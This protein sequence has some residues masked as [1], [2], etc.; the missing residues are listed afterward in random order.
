M[1]VLLQLS[2]LL[3]PPEIKKWKKKILAFCH[4][5]TCRGSVTQVSGP[6]RPPAS[7]SQLTTC[8][9]GLR[10]APTERTRATPRPAATAVSVEAN[11]EHTLVR[12]SSC[13]VV[14]PVAS[15]VRCSGI[16]RC[17]SLSC[18]HRCHAS[19]DGGSCACPLGYIVSGNDSRTCIGI[20]TV[21]Q[22]QRPLIKFWEHKRNIQ[23]MLW[24][25]N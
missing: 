6:V 9:T 5:T 18:Q 14:W 13:P 24:I 16:W 20:Y 19:P 15:S 11:T 7:A 21:L 12:A 22:G 23:V 10:T 4:Q 3:W 17:A 1:E 8:V 25:E 2:D